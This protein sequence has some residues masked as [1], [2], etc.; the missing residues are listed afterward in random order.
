MAQR[1]SF[2]FAH[3]CPKIDKAI[4]QCKERVEFALIPI[5]QSICE[6][7]PDEK[8][9]E[10]AKKYT[11]E[12]YSEVEYCFESIRETN[13]EMRDS[14]NY[15]IADLEDEIEQLKEEIKGIENQL[16]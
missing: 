16:Y 1:K 8:A 4:A 9:A 2:D 12:V 13:E 3:T 15:Q 11:L 7:I 6:H 5:I 10:L 14:A